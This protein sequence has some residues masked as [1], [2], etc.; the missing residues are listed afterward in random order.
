MRKRI[1]AIPG[2]DSYNNE[3]MKNKNI[4]VYEDDDRGIAVVKIYGAIEEPM[5]Y[6]DEISKLDELSKKLNVVE[7]TLNSPGGSINTTV[8]IA[9]IISNFEYVV[10]IGKG[11]IAS[12]AFMLWTMGDIRVVTN[13]STYMAHRESYGMYGKTAEHRDAAATFGRVYEEMFEECFGDL[14][15]ETEKNI[16]ER[17]EAWITYKDLLERDNVI[18]YDEYMNPANPYKVLE[19]Y[20]MKENKFFMF[21]EETESF[22]N[23]EWS[24][25]NEFIA[26][27][28]EHLYGL[29]DIITVSFD[30][31]DGV[32]FVEIIEEN[33]KKNVKSSKRTKKDT[34]DE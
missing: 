20:K 22:R 21:D 13:Y 30:D 18:S 24:F 7:I 17:S 8:D 29:S 2:K 5:E 14:L 9:S 28:T 15:T 34:P 1:N 25:G 6:I 12:A 32:D 16:A 23:V 19:L 11:E 4:H 33:P 26:D 27:M 10:T 3:P 31:E